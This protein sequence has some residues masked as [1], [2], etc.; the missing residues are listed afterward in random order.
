MKKKTTFILMAFVMALFT[1]TSCSDDDNTVTVAPATN[2][3]ADFVAA[4]SDYSSLGAALDRAGLT[5]VLDGDTEYTVFAPNNTAFDTFL[6]DNGFANLEA[7]PVDVLTQ[8]LLNHVVNGTNTSGNLTT[9]YIETLAQEA[10]TGNTLNMY[11]NTADGVVLNGISTVSTA[12][13]PVDNG[14]IHAVN[15]VIG[16]PT[17]VTF[18]TADA[19][20]SSLVAALTRETSFTYVA[21]L[22]TTGTPAP[23]T[24]FAPTNQAFTNLIGELEG[25][26]DLAD[27]PTATL[28]ATLNTHVIAGANV[29][30]STLMDGMTV[31]NT[32]GADFTINT[33]GGAS[34]TDLNGRM[35]DIVVTDVQAANGVIHVISEVILPQL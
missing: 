18:A 32:L 2:T 33:A 7:V 21:T 9:G 6:S 23:F 29:L 12:D 19:T 22:S 35:G 24:V 10:T 3:I 30:A 31:D 11:V 20:F 27:I 1:L 25:V 17:V 26:N 34:F 8:V 15:S 4:N 13:V 16:L 14:V 28:E 5:S